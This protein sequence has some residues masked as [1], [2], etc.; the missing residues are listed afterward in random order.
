MGI[1]L[2]FHSGNNYWTSD[3]RFDDLKVTELMNIWF[4]KN[5]DWSPNVTYSIAFIGSAVS[6]DINAPAGACID[7]I[8]ESQ[9]GSVH[10][11][12]YIDGRDYV[13]V[14]YEWA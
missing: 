10:S 2:S 8:C 6:A 5:C 11:R 3:K 14:D 13:T 1:P 12:I 7:N 9:A 4:Y